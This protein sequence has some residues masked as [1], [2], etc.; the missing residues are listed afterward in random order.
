MG[1]YAVELLKQN[2]SSRVVAIKDGK[3]VDYDI[4]EALAMKKPF[5]KDVYDMAHIVS[6]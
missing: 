5:P 6:I 1:Y 3:I 2:K 4:D